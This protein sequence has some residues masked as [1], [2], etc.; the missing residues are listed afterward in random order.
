[1]SIIDRF[2]V[3]LPREE[4]VILD[5]IQAYATWQVGRQDVDFAPTDDD[6]VEIRNYLLHLRI[7]RLQPAQL[8]QTILSLQRFY[9]WALAEG[10]IN[11]DPFREFDYSRPFLSEDELRRRQETLPESPAER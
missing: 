4:R 6:D 3:T 11:E 7:S 2:A 9:D 5:D 8:E 1:M 10:V